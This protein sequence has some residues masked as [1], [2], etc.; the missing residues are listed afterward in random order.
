MSRSAAAFFNTLDMK[1]E[2]TG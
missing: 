2:Q 1:L